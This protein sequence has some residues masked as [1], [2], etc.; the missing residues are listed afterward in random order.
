M[1]WLRVAGMIKRWFQSMARW[2]PASILLALGGCSTLVPNNTET[3]RPSAA[4]QRFYAELE[5]TVQAEGLNPEDLRAAYPAADFPFGPAPVVRVQVARSNQPELVQTFGTYV[6]RMV[7]DPRIAAGRAQL[8]AHAGTLQR[9]Q[10]A[11]GVPAEVLVALWGIESNFGRNQGQERV[12]PALVTLAWESNRPAYFRREALQA[13]RV[14]EVSGIAPADLRGS[15]AGALGQC[16]F[17]PSNYV[18]L[19]RDG[20]GDGRVDIWDSVDD[21]LASTAHYLQQRGWQAGVPWRVDVP[22]TPKLKGLLVNERGLSAPLRAKEWA[23]RGVPAAVMTKFPAD[24]MV[25]WYQPEKSG[26]G[27]LLGPNFGVI[28]DWNNSSY[29]A[30]SV[31]TLADALAKPPAQANAEQEE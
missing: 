4:F 30:Y 7:S 14:A 20:D 21:V 17:M 27:M 1:N 10:G 9:I 24:A 6:Q 5:Q 29:F 11:Y 3:L 25:R 15:W 16:Q 13:L 2:L 8:V 23:G 22:H 12:I 26:A 19:G 18:K 28:L 31:L